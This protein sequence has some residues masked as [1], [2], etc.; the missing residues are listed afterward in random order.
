MSTR[1]YLCRLFGG[2]DL[3]V[4]YDGTNI[5]IMGQTI[6]VSSLS[7]SLQAQW[8][9]AIGGASTSFSPAGALRPAFGGDNIGAA[10]GAILDNQPAMR[11]AIAAAL[12]TFPPEILQP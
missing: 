9:A 6:A 2:R 3:A 10:V 4:T 7:S 1:T 11:T 12:A 5:A 8:Q